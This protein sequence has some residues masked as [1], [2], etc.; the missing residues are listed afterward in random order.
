MSE[1]LTGLKARYPQFAETLDRLAILATQKQI[2]QLTGDV[3]GFLSSATGIVSGADLVV[4]FEGFV[5]K[6]AERMNSVDVVCMINSCTTPV[7]V[8]ISTGIELFDRYS[9]VAKKSKDATVLS[10]VYRSYLHLKK[11]HEVSS[12]RAEVDSVSDLL[13]DPL[14][15]HVVSGSVRGQYHLASAEMYLAMGSND[16]EFYSH[17][18]KYL[19]YTP[20]EEISPSDRVLRT[21]R[22]GVIAL[23]SPAINDFGDLLSLRI[24]QDASSG[25]PAW[26]VDF[27][28]AVHLGDFARFDSAIASHGALLHETE[29]A[30]M[31]QIESSLRTK[32]V[33]IALAELAAF[34]SPERDRRLTFAQ[35]ANECRVPIDQVE[36]LVMT[37]M[38]TGLI[39]GTI[40]EVDE[41]V[42]VTAVRPRTLDPDRMLILKTRIEAWSCKATTLLNGMKEATPELLVD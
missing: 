3:R 7:D 1:V 9:S 41:T 20:L 24:F 18:V 27:L 22:A 8:A 39:T 32:L 11:S 28:R 29:S 35:I 12:A 30:L 2:H 5:S 26:L 34:K 13:Q 37:T 23:I 25:C 31:K 6:F 21:K 42:T 33:M 16:L 40:D 17:L 36:T 15:S 4:F 38:G 10:K 19:T 14:W